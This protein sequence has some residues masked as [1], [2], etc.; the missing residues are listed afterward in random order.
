MD[1]KVCRSL[2]PLVEGKIHGSL[3]L[4]IDEVIWIKRNP[5]NIIVVASWWGEYNSAQFR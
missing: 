5:G 2:P 4:I 3:K 1:I